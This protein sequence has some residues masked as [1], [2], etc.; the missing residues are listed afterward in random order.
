VIR[1]GKKSFELQ[2]HI[3]SIPIIAQK[4]CDPVKEQ[5]K[6]SHAWTED[7]LVPDPFRANVKMA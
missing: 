2:N 1:A 3:K 6:H 5:S 7:S 4:S